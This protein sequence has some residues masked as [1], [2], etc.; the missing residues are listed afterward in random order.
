MKIVLIA[1]VV[2]VVGAAAYALFFRLGKRPQSIESS[3]REFRD[4]LAA[5]DPANDPLIRNSLRVPADPTRVA[6]TPP[7]DRPP[8][9]GPRPG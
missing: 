6:P 1:A 2:L 9:T 7:V 5:L 4:G 8:T 3:M